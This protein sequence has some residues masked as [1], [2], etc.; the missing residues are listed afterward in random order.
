[1]K[2]SKIIY[3]QLSPIKIFS[4]L[5]FSYVLSALGN[6]L[7]IEKNEYSNY[8]ILQYLVVCIIGYIS[9]FVSYIN[10]KPIIK[11]HK[12]D[13]K[14]KLKLYN[15][16][17]FFT[18]FIV[19]INYNYVVSLLNPYRAVAYTDRIATLAE[20]TSDFNG[21][22]SNFNDL[23]FLLIY[24][25]L[26]YKSIMNKKLNKIVLLLGLLLLLT[27]V[28]SGSKS[29][30]IFYFLFI[31]ISYIS[32]GNKINFYLLS[33]L[34]IFIYVFSIMIS[35][36]RNTTLLLEMF[37]NGKDIIFDNLLILSPLNSGE[38]I[39]PK[40]L[41]KIIDS[42]NNNDVSLSY[43]VNILNDFISFIPKFIWSDRP[44][45]TSLYYAK[46]FFPNDFEK[47]LGFGNFILTEGYLSFG[48]L[49][50]ILEML[51]F[52]LFL[53]KTYIFFI[54]RQDSPLYVFLYVVFLQFFL[55]FCIRTGFVISLKTVFLILSPFLLI[56]FIARVK[57]KYVNE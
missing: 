1:M 25:S 55:L 29:V 56:D 23:T 45:N 16:F 22:E 7:L 21:A 52:G 2:Q 41:M 35:H 47:G 5:Y 49:G 44:L 26:F 32:N 38:L 37:A 4:L 57:N 51:F 6:V 43:G 31:M 24:L 34:L 15:I 8:V 46:T 10:Y 20:G 50:V 17:L 30:L 28:M 9:F 54:N 48:I 42:I 12:Y 18:F 11:F 33:P 13:N 53:K 40:N 27:T 36:V 19:I 3:D 39:V 14:Y